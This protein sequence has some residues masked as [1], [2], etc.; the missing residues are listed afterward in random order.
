MTQ[1][2]LVGILC[3]LIL[4]SGFFSGSETGL[5]SINRYRLKHL[6]KKR[7]PGAKRVSKMLERPDRLLGVI[8]LGNTFTNIVASSVATMW[9]VSVFGDLGP[10]LSTIILTFVIL[11]F[12]EMT[13]KTL[14]ALSP[15]R[16]AFAVSL[17]LMV[18]QKICYPLVWILSVISNSF[19]R[20]FGVKIRPAGADPIS[21]D[22]LRTDCPRGTRENFCCSPRNVATDI[23]FGGCYCE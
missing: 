15:E 21:K 10:L 1:E 9:A 22:E 18:L 8:L 5:M 7:H 11:I 17:P 12:S 16:V 14:A 6:I 20:L 4:L 2:G 13:P 23:G 19:L 3:I